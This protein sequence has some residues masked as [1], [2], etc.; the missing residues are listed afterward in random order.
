MERGHSRSPLQNFSPSPATHHQRCELTQPRVS[1][2]SRQSTSNPPSHT[3]AL[4]LLSKCAPDRDPPVR[5]HVCQSLTLLLVSRPDKLMPG[6]ANVTESFGWSLL[7]T[8]TQPL[9]C[10]PFCRKRRQSCWTARSTA[11][12]T[13]EQRRGCSCYDGKSYG[14]DR[15]QRF[16]APTL[17]GIGS[18]S[19]YL[20]PALNIASVG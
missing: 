14:L 4:C 7:R 2:S 3:S 8:S 10:T 6:M 17:E 13:G 15:K 11:K 16:F 18:S 20:Y 19:L 5:G 12:M 1:P 9:G